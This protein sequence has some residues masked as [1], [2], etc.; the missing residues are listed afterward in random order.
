MHTLL[1]ERVTRFFVE[2][3]GM[4]EVRP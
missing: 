2:H 3:F 1:N 4:M